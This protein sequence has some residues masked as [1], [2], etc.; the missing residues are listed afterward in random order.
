MPVCVRDSY[1]CTLNIYKHGVASLFGVGMESPGRF[2]FA[3]PPLPRHTSTRATRGVDPAA[4]TPGVKSVH[5]PC[6]A[7]LQRAPRY[8]ADASINANVMWSSACA[9][10]ST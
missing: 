1:A 8:F 4:H 3:P 7:G 6:Q 10:M 9:N 5:A 2:H